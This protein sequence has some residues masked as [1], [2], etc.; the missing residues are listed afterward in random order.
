MQRPLS[1]EP[2]AVDLVNT[3]WRGAGGLQDLL[4]TSEG[5]TQWL[6]ERN[7]DAQPGER[8]RGALT[9]AR[10]VLRRAFRQEPGTEDEVNAILARAVIVRSL[11]DGR[12]TERPLFA[13]EAWR[14]AWLA[15]NDYLRLRAESLDGIRPCGHPSCV[16]YF[17]DPTGRRRW[18]SMARCGNRAKAHRHYTRQQSTR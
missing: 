5:L 6:A 3:C 1:G 10:E 4:A 11:V 15:V 9:Q 2:L 8:V 14:P 17:Y 7:L 13:D 18:C 16:L 12:A